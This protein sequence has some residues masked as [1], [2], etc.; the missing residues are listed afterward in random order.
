MLFSHP[1]LGHQFS[2]PPLPNNLSNSLTIKDS[3]KP[4][5]YLFGED[6]E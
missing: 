5:D 3:V 4:S 2:L 1:I 6:E